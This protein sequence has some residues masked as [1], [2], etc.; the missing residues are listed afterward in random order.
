VREID[1][2]PATVWWGVQVRQWSL[3]TCTVQCTRAVIL[4][5]SDLLVRSGLLPRPVVVQLKYSPPTVW[6]LGDHQRFYNANAIY[7][8]RCFSDR[9]SCSS[10][11]NH[12]AAQRP[13]THIYVC[14]CWSPEKTMILCIY[15]VCKAFFCDHLQVFVLLIK[16][17][18]IDVTPYFVTYRLFFSTC[19][20]V[21]AWREV[22]M[23]IERTSGTVVAFISW[24][25]GRVMHCNQDLE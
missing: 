5:S 11:S 14:I 4:C 21:C 10:Y 8:Q 1:D 7:G 9:Q 20:L 17:F 22:R 6:L 23:G 12:Y 3:H 15:L 16:H 25:R 19:P 24:E 18:G 2:L 13:Y